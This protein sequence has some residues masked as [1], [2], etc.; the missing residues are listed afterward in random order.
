MCTEARRALGPKGRFILEEG[1]RYSY[2]HETVQGSE[3]QTSGRTPAVPN[4][5]FLYVIRR[6]CR[7]F[8]CASCHFNHL[9]KE[10]QLEGIFYLTKGFD[11]QILAS[12]QNL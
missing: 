11:G 5:G 10:L 3:G 12:A 1:Q 2:V 7:K 9:G 6:G 4:R 8:G